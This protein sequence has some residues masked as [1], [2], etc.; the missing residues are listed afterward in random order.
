M[1]EMFDSYEKSLNIKFIIMSATL[2]RLDRLLDEKISNFVTLLMIQ[3]DIIKM[4]YLE[5]E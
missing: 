4:I 2:P 5:K 1:I 3:K